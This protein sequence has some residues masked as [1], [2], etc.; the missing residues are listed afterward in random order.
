MLKL[1]AVIHDLCLALLV[2]GLG[3]AFVAAFVLFDAAPN[4]EI[5]GQVG[6]AIFNLLG[7]G[8]LVVTILLVASRAFLGSGVAPARLSRIGTALA[9]LTVLLAAAIALWLTPAMD[10]IWRT[11]PHAPDGTGL[12]GEDHARFMRLHGAGSASYLAVW[13][14]A[15]V[16]LM[17]RS[18]AS[19]RA[20]AA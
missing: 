13:L 7:P 20:P 2:G 10:V 8:T 11:G 16:L 14:I 3:A 19:M 12:A 9:V 15:V 4:H 18:G 17:M 1:C 5:A 6:Q